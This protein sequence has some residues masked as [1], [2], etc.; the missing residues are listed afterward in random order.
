LGG[1]RLENLPRIHAE[2]VLFL[3]LV[4]DDYS[5]LDVIYALLAST[6]LLDA[7]LGTYADAMDFYRK[8]LKAT[9]RMAE[10]Y[11]RRQVPDDTVCSART[12]M[13]MSFAD[14][15]CDDAKK[16]K[17]MDTLIATNPRE[18]GAYLDIVRIGPNEI[19]A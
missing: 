14:P 5:E 1:Y 4:H 6:T 2:C 7:R 12:M 18:F 19:V 3:S 9:S 15:K 10:V 11:G 13:K 16:R 8:S 17:Q